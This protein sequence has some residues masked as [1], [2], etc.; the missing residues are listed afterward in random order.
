MIYLFI[1]NANKEVCKN[2]IWTK[3]ILFSETERQN[4]ETLDI[5]KKWKFISYFIVEQLILEWTWD[6]DT[7]QDT[8]TLLIWFSKKPQAFIFHHLQ[9]RTS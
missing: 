8:E 1:Y 4:Q 2:W 9:Q 3:N 6:L 5:C 7:E